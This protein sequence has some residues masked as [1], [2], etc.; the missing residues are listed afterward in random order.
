MSDQEYFAHPYLNNSNLKNF[1]GPEYR[2]SKRQALHKLQNPFK[3]TDATLLGDLFHEGMEH[4]WVKTRPAPYSEFRTNEAKEWKKKQNG[5]VYTQ[6][7][8][9]TAK[10]MLEAVKLM[11]PDVWDIARSQTTQAEREVYNHDLE[12]KCKEDLFDGVDGVIWDWK[13]CQ[14]TTPAGIRKSIDT[15]HYDMAQY[16]YLQTDEDAKDFMW[17]FVQSDA[18]YEVVIVPGKPVLE[19]GR[20]KWET[21]YHRYKNRMKGVLDA[22]TIDPSYPNEFPQQIEEDVEI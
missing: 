12:T 13:S 4:G 8:V 1:A 20:L 5:I 11:A 2:Y 6:K 7:M 16:H 17:L 9:D 10:Y 15:L 21:A 3:P 18:P 22:P 19:R 14:D